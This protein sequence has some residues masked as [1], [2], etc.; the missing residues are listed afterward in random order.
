MDKNTAKQRIEKLIAQIED[1]RYRY[2][3]LND[4][5]VTDEVKDALEKE[6]KKLEAEFPDL[7]QKNSPVSR[8]AGKPLDKFVKVKHNV[9]ML[10]LN[11][12]FSKDELRD[13]ETR[14][15]KILVSQLNRKSANRKSVSYFAEVKFD[16]LAV[17]LIYENGVFVRGATRGDGFIGE[18]ITQNLKTIES[19]PLKLRA[20][21]PNYIEIRGEAI[22]PKKVLGELNRQ[23]EKEGKQ[24][25]ANTRNAAAGSLRQLDSSLTAKRKLDFYAYDIVQLDEKYNP[26][27]KHSGLHQMLREFGFK[28]LEKYECKTESLKDVNNFIDK[29]GKIRAGLPFGIDGVVISVDEI[30]AQNI[31]GVVGKA[32]RYMVAYKFAAEKATTIIKEIRVNVGRTGVLTPLAV[33][34][35]TLVAGSTIGK[36]TLHNMDQIERLDVRVGDTVI[37][38]KAGDVIPE[39]VEVLTKMRTGKEKKFKMLDKC[40]VCGSPVKKRALGGKEETSTAYYCSNAKCPAKNRRFMQ[41]F[42]SVLE[43]YEIGPKILDRFQAEGLISDAADIFALEESDIK[44]L[45]RFGEKSAENIIASINEHRKITLPRFIFS[46][47]ILHIGEQTSEDLAKHFKTLE[48]LKSISLEEINNIENIG[49]VV[50]KSV[51]EYF[52]NK[53]NLKFIE[54]L[55]KNGVSILP[56]KSQTISQKLAGK[57]FVIT[58]TLETMSRDDAKKK[59]KELGGKITESVSK[60]TSFVVVGNEP[61]SKYQKALKEGVPVLSEKELISLIQP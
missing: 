54:K 60:Q 48:K 41:H 8:V 53:D 27:K 56:Y 30:L 14:V 15:N 10:S 55:F 44:E 32:P 18:D 47:G 39:V 24:L 1:L 13:W 50:S 49:P 33:F 61:G 2:H 26:I 16:G 37:I 19:I 17:S 25:F 21:F 59:I 40:P 22:M 51:F 28:T 31:L 9:R 29:I 43:I 3:V 38:Q 57:T 11:D 35:P 5:A 4:L 20:P 42:V 36:A 52:R 6:L 23:Q 7:A 12:V 58:G 46:L 45:E 34:E